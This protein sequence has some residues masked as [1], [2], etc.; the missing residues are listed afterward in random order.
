MKQSILIALSKHQMEVDAYVRAALEDVCSSDFIKRTI[1][2]TA[3]ETLFTV[4]RDEVSAFFRFG[5]GRKAV[6]EAVKAKLLDGETYTPLDDVPA[7]P[8]RRSSTLPPPIH[9]PAPWSA[10][11]E[12]EFVYSV[13][14]ATGLVIADVRIVDTNDDYVEVPDDCPRIDGVDANVTL[15]EAAPHLLAAL[16][17]II[18]HRDRMGLGDN[19]IYAAARELIIDTNTPK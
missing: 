10:D 15:I 11:P 9:S 3:E 13:E 18:E 5:E 7:K 14:D 16:T 12:G 19:E 2:N 6:A 1:D 4:I 8:A 17:A